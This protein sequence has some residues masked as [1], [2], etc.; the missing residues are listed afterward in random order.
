M[1][2]INKLIKLYTPFICAVMSAIH[3]VCFLCKVTD[4]FFLRIIGDFT[5]HSFLLLAFV[6]IHSKRMC[7][8]YKLSIK[9]LFCIHILNLAYYEIGLVSEWALI[10]GGLVLNIASMMCWLIFIT[11]RTVYKTV[12]STHTDL[13]EQE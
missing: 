9:F 13:E 6:W 8:W 10:Y 3:G 12:C 7:K 4:I 1:E 5:G 11:L 2:T